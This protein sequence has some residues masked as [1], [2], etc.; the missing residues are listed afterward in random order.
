MYKP[1][2]SKPNFIE[3]EHQILK[4]WE[5]T[6]AFQKLRDKIR[7]NK[8]W[9]FLDGPITANNPMGVHHAWGR[10]YKDIYQRYKAMNGFDQRFVNGFDCQGL[11]IEVEVEKELGFKS[12]IDIET[13]GIAKFVD[14][15]K[16]RVRHF[17]DMIT[18]QSIRLGQWMDWENSYYTFSDT[19]NYTIW[20]FLRKCHDHGWIYKGA[21]VMPWCPRC[22]TG[23]SQHEIATEGYQEL[24]H[25]GVTLLFPLTDLPGENLLVWTTT[26]WTL[27]SNVSAAVGPELAYVKV[28]NQER[29]LY[30]SKGALPILEGEY[31]ILEELPGSKM[32]GWRYAGPFDDLP[33]QQMAGGYTA[34]KGLSE[35]LDVTSVESHRVIAWEEVGEEEGTGIVHIAP[36]CG[37][38]DFALGK[39]YGLPPIAP[40]T[41][42]GKFEG[43]FGWL[44]GKY[45][46]EVAEPI[47]EDLRKKG[48][49]Y[50]VE[51]YTH[52]YPVCWRCNSELI[53]RLVD[54]WFIKMDDLRHQIM[55]VAKK[56]TW[57][58]EYGLDLELDWLKNMRD[59]MI[60]KKRYYGLALPIFQCDS[61]GHFD[62]IGGKE[63]LKERAVE[64]WD[65]F[66]G[67]AP[68][69]PWV[70]EVK[71]SC[72]KCGAKV[73]RI[74]DVGNPWL[75]AGIVPYSTMGYTEDRVHWEKWFPAD[76]ITECFPGQFRNWFYCLLAMSTVMENQEPFKY[77]LGHALVKDQHGKEMHKSAG[78]A[79]RFDDA[80]EVIG[81]DAMRWIFAEHN[82]LT[83]L[84][85]SYDISKEVTRKLLTLWNT[86]SF[87][88]TYAELDGWRPDSDPGERNLMDR[89]VLSRL[90]TTIE[91]CREAIDAYSVAAAVRELE[92]TIDMVSTWYVRR[93]R[94]RFWKSSNDSDKA[95]AYH[96]LYT[97]LTTLIRLLAPILP[98]LTEELHGALV[99][100]ANPDAPV[101]VH[102]ESYPEADAALKDQALESAMVDIIDIVSLARSLRN[103]I[104]ITVRQPLSE[105]KVVINPQK[106]R[107]A[108]TPL[109][110][111]ITQ[112]IN[113]KEITL[114]DDAEDLIQYTAKPNLKVL[115]PRLGAKM[116][117][118]GD[119][120]AALDSN[121]VVGVMNGESVSV[122]G[123][124]LT[125]DDI[126]VYR[127]PLAGWTV[128]EDG[129]ITT[130]LKVMITEELRSEGNA[131]EFV[132]SVQ[133]LRKEMDFNVEDRI[134]ITVNPSEGLNSALENHRDFICREI[135]A[136][137][138]VL[139]FDQTDGKKVKINDEMAEI[140]LKKDQNFS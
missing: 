129:E 88:A 40:L 96:T 78:N 19:N 3:I 90:Q 64:G 31:K 109:L 128:K 99:R 138:F 43:E 103:D 41:E 47:F 76:F 84:N 117:Q 39:E 29:I 56:I 87:F 110:S 97:V 28:L 68:H 15:C 77:L 134:I 5:E 42:F 71:I 133:N 45:V 69:R 57:F 91:K 85:F 53:F 49:L 101:S 9:S 17:S 14:K 25:A 135:L 16:D 13:Y 38:E 63:E 81:A 139:E 74:Q 32:V 107:E 54:E 70:D 24:T 95:S 123:L 52:R 44:S 22:A 62:I 59:W 26:P 113:V 20:Q 23:I 37:A 66:E 21:D 86:A 1:L 46:A 75:D 106:R 82:P 89:W 8:H 130:A 67:N 131:R 51:D 80:A 55:D 98:F 6:Q 112:E 11:W 115:G 132:H 27:T 79:I 65:K 61:C 33:A 10:T 102:L 73:S 111:Q 104:G 92:T 116:K 2:N 18:A 34:I 58:P 124:S 93:S 30:L 4:Y 136:T 60:S 48:I 140:W 94:R 12:K 83:N 118:V 127:E 126:V 137:D 36:G 105:L 100:E 108:I 50:K 121:T 114:L 125:A 120:I 122:E 119:A 7:G 35:K 72:Q